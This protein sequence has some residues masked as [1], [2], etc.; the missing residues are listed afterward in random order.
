ME[1]FKICPYCGKRNSTSALECE[2]CETDIS[3][4]RVMDD[5]IINQK[6]TTTDAVA[7]V[8]PGTKVRICEGCG[9]QNLANARKCSSCGE[10]ISDVTPTDAPEKKE[11]H[12]ILASLDGEYAYPLKPG[13]TVIGRE[14]EM[15]E[16]LS[17]K[18]FVSRRH[19]QISLEDGKV[20]IENYSHT[21]YTY[22]NNQKLVDEILELKDGD[23]IGLGGNEKNGKKQEQAAY[24]MMRIGSCI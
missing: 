11:E 9:R 24:F 21:N 13:K 19:A 3:T 7:T 1:K 18:S 10:D 22:I 2:E 20:T 12:Y 5:V 8:K 16:Y 14:A 17:N 4:V 15:A 23:E 6:D